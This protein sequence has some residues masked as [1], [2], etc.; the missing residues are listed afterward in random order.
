[1]SDFCIEC[2]AGYTVEANLTGRS[3]G[4]DHIDRSYNTRFASGAGIM[5]VAIDLG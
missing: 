1:M 3:Y 2:T 5:F 4:N